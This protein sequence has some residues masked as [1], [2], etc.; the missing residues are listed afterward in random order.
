MEKRG[1]LTKAMQAFI[2]QFE[3]EPGQ[4]YLPKDVAGR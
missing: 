2:T 4:Y 1:W 3:A